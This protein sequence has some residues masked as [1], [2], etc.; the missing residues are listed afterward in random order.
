VRV[1]AVLGLGLGV[2]RRQDDVGDPRAQQPQAA[3]RPAGASRDRGVERRIGAPR[4]PAPA[5]AVTAVP[6]VAAAARRVQRST[7]TVAPGSLA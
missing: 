2:E 1:D 5:V 4:S 7:T 6:A 3:R